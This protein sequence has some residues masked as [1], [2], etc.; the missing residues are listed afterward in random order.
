MTPYCLEFLYHP[1]F[2][3][4]TISIFILISLTLSHF[5]SH[6]LAPYP[7]QNPNQPN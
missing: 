3:S 6:S 2:F 7:A 4:L 5:H 1:S